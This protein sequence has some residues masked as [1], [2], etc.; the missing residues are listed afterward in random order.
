MRAEK[1]RGARSPSYVEV[2]DERYFMVFLGTNLSAP[3][4]KINAQ[5]RA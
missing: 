2:Y 3:K 1:S 5:K 4:I